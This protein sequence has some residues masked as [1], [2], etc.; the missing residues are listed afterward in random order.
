M[1]DWYLTDNNVKYLSS[2]YTEKV[3]E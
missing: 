2:E 3:D 1:R